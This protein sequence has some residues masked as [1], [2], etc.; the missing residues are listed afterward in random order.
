MTV[1]SHRAAVMAMLL[2]VPSIGRVHPSVRFVREESKFRE[3]YLWA[4]PGGLQHV[5]GW[6]LQSP[7]TERRSWGMGRVL[8]KHTWSI[9][10]YLVLNLQ[11][12]SQ[13]V[14]DDLCEAVGVAHEGDRTLGGV[15]TAEELGG[16]T[17]GVQKLEAGEV[18]FCSTLCHS[19]LLQLE[20]WE[21]A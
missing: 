4:P 19:A 17:S 16:E 5:R 12:E 7:T 20:T 1:A 21:Y 9:R 15:S 10:G 13:L 6:H 11:E 8:L 3:A 14:F 18:M 2:Q